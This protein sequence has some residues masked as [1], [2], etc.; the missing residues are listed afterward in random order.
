MNE[1]KRLQEI[2]EKTQQRIEDYHIHI[3]GIE[4]SYAAMVVRD[5]LR[6]LFAPYIMSESNVR[7]VGP[8]QEANYAFVFN[9]RV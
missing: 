3:Y 9:K 7:A 6:R 5:D 2:W 1:D 4:R 8:H